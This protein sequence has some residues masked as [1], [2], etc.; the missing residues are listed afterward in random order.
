MGR[1]QA[2]IAALSW[3][4]HILSSAC[5]D[6]SIW[7]H[8]SDV[9]VARHKVMELLGHSECELLASGRNHNMVIA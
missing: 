7:H 9:R 4:G 1:Y 2:P 8:D 5:G 3:H 6:G